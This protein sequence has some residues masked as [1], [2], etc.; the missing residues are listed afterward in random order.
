M[1][2]LSDEQKLEKRIISRFNKAV[3]DYNLIEDND[4]I[5]I[6]LSGGKD[7]LC[8][9]ELLGRRQRI[10]SP[11]FSIVALHIRMENIRYESD[12]SYLQ[13]FCECWG[14]KF[15][16]V[17]TGFDYSTTDRK[18]AC[19]LC[20]WNRRKQLFSM[21]QQLGCN[22]IALGHHRD[23]IIHT[24]MMNLFF[25]GCFSTMPVRLR[26]RKMPLS[27]VRPLCLEDETDLRDY[28]VLRNYMR[29]VKLCPYET[30]TY[31]NDM[32]G[33]FKQVERMSAE[34]RYSVWKALEKENKLVEE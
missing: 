8:L 7:S 26:M 2:L 3:Y 27:I 17:T 12:V 15:Y 23:D 19:F 31:R 33:I 18:P 20:S 22:K 28:A 4:K 32:R 13:E 10:K 24:T 6:G 5:L 9:V 29:Q 14:A 1:P 25:Q 16:T 30:S 11:S 34:A 21:A